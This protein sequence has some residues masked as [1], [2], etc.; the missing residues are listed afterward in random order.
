MISSQRSTIEKTVIIYKVM[1][2]L[3]NKTDVRKTEPIKVEGGKLLT[4]DREVSNAFNCFF[5]QR[6][7]G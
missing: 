4:D 3:R 5:I 7:K 6:D 2:K 1:N